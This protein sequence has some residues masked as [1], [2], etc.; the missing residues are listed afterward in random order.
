M[1]LKDPGQSDKRRDF[2]RAEV[3]V[4]DDGLLRLRPAPTAITPQISFIE[5]YRIPRS[6]SG[7]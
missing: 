6:D 4:G 3:T 5:I 1:L 7:R 2:Y